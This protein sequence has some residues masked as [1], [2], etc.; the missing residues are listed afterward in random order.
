VLIVDPDPENR[1]WLNEVA[2]TVAKTVELAPA[3]VDPESGIDP[4][5]HDLVI[6]NID[7]F[8]RDA[9]M[10]ILRTLRRW[11]AMS[12][13]TRGLLT[14]DVKRGYDELFREL[15]A[16]GLMNLLAKNEGETNT[17]DLVATMRKILENKVFGI[18]RYFPSDVVV[19]TMEITSSDQVMELFE[20]AQKF[21]K[22]IKVHPRVADGFGTAAE[23]LVMNALFNAPVD[24]EGKQKYAQEPRGE[25]LVVEPGEEVTVTLARSEKRLGVSV[26]DRFGELGIDRCLRRLGKCFRMGDA[27][28]EDKQNGAGLGLY[29]SFGAVSQL[30]VNIAPQK[31]TEVL[32]LIDVQ[33]NYREF[34]SRTKSFNSFVEA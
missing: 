20:K 19:E 12:R 26:R 21:A 28:V 5:A 18:E 6:I 15:R 33:R 13:A 34:A 32:G 23:E 16:Y 17:F 1:A 30:V 31:C 11:G 25:T 24:S 4:K 10:K 22:G 27:Q 2:Q 29:V 9:R 7:A 8:D 3:D 14:S